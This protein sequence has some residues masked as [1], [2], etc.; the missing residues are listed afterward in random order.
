ML[1]NRDLLLILF[2]ISVLSIFLLSKGILYGHVFLLLFGGNQSSVIRAQ[3]IM[4]AFFLLIQG[5]KE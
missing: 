1:T 3:Q 5:L 2:L 4:T